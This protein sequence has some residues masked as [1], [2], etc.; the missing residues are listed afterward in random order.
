MGPWARVVNDLRFRVTTN[1][2]TLAGLECEQDGVKEQLIRIEHRLR[3]MSQTMLFM[4]TELN[5]L[6]KRCEENE[7]KQRIILDAIV[8]RIQTGDKNNK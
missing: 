7:R 6:T 5:N 1:E 4:K 2:E 8:T 3:E